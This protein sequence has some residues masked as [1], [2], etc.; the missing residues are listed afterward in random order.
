MELEKTDNDDMNEESRK[1][2]RNSYIDLRKYNSR[3]NLWLFS[4]PSFYL[5]EI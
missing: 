3:N 2:W 4:I 5:Y 1:M